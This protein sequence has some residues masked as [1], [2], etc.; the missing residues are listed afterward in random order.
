MR[1]KSILAI[2]VSTGLI[3]SSLTGCA[4]SQV[5][6]AAGQTQ[7]A[8]QEEVQETTKQ[9]E[10]ADANEPD[11]EEVTEEP[12]QEE[13]ADDVT[14]RIGTLASQTQPALAW[15]KEYFKEEGVSVEIVTFSTGP[16]EVEAF[17]SG[18]LD[19]ILVGDLP[20]LNGVNNGV[21][22]QVVAFYQSSYK[23]CQLAV[24]DEANIK[25]FA[26]LKGK[27]VSVP[28]GSNAQPILYEMLEKGGLTEDDIELIN[29]SA[30]DGSNAL[31]SKDVDAAITWDPF[32]ANAVAEGGISVLADTTD[33]RPLV[34]PILSSTQFVNEHHDAVE[35]TLKALYRA[36]IWAKANVEEAA[37]LV[38]DYFG[39]DS[40]DSY[41]ISISNKDLDIRLTDEKLEALKKGNESCYRF[42]ITEALVDVDAHVISDFKDLDK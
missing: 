21:D 10:D 1:I 24:R 41:I 30:A 36:G 4:A 16:A 28:V 23:D 15:Q 37:A 2:I 13:S 40:A 27:K 11:T 5:Q 17:T 35:R 14:V 26:D 7:P 39:A 8:A 33:F 32:I 19:L 12:V 38:A 18:D 20:F 34:C 22:L 3:L 29:L 6:A 25:S 9:T 42:G 31:I